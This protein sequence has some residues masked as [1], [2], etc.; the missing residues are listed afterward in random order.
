MA[1]G[2]THIDL[3]KINTEGYELQVLNGFNEDFLKQKVKFIYAEAGF[4]K[5]DVLKN[6]Y[7][8]LDARLKHL[9]F[10][11]SGFY[12]PF[13]WGKHKLRLGFCNVLFVNIN[14]LDR[15]L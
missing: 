5:D 6:N 9:G 2:I 12:E 7:A 15:G 3:L 1:N 14:L 10:T 13:R 11:T 4:E 8:D